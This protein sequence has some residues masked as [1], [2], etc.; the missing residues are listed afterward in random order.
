MFLE[1]F[2]DYGIL[3]PLTIFLVSVLSQVCPLFSLLKLFFMSFPFFP[4]QFHQQFIYF[5]T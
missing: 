3:F 4:D 5:I 1:S 2:K